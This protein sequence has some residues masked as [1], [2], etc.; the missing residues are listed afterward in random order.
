MTQTQIPVAN[1]ENKS[2]ARLFMERR[3]LVTGH[4]FGKMF[5]GDTSEFRDQ[6]TTNSLVAAR[7]MLD[8]GRTNAACRLV[9]KASKYQN[10]VSACPPEI[11]A[12]FVSLAKSI[13]N[14]IKPAKPELSTGVLRVGA[15]FADGSEKA[16]MS[17]S[18]IS[19]SIEAA[20]AMPA[21]SSSKAIETLTLARTVATEDTQITVLSR[22]AAG[23][24]FK[25]A[26]DSAGSS[27]IYRLDSVSGDIATAIQHDPS[28][29]TEFKAW[30]AGC[31]F[32]EAKSLAGSSRIYRLDSV[33]KS[34]AT[35]ISHN[36]SRE[37]ELKAWLADCYIAEAESNKW[38]V[39]SVLQSLKNALQYANPDQRER[40]LQ[41]HGEFAKAQ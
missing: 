2:V 18:A 27:R 5:R 31:Y 38:N 37:S 29:T 16:T 19:A 36:P 26:K 33:S 25:R 6:I 21:S 35:A 22:A 12:L 28:R 39:A 20:E 41:M 17:K 11:K 9:L 30:L 7:K 8:L 24:Y 23:V 32:E 1:Y 4:A 14:A 15:C 10:D 13:S 34:I 3:T 40:I